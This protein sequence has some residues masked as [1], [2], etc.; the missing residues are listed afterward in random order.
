MTMRKY[1]RNRR[2][3]PSDDS[4]MKSLHLTIREAAKRGPGLHHRKPAM[5]V[6][7]ILFGEERVPIRE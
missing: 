1:T 7:Q 5:Q 6:F 3:F 2:I 4:A